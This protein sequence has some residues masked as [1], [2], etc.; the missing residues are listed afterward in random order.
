[1][2]LIVLL[3]VT[4][5]LAGEVVLGP[6]NRFALE[7]SQDRFGARSHG[8]VEFFGPNQ[9]KFSPL[10]QSTAKDYIRLRSED[11]RVNPFVLEQ[12]EREE[13]IGPHQVEA[14]RVWFGKQFYDSEEM[15]GVGGF[16]YFDTSNRKY[17]LS[18][19][20]EIAR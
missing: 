5:S 8:I 18:S 19:P 7:R 10:P 3:L 1:M 17:T 6:Q 16:G 2:R 13:V 12:Y 11:L 9:T 14:G 15:R 4:L 20:P